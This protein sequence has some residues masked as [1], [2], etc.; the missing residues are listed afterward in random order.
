MTDK[1]PQDGGFIGNAGCTHENHEHSPLVERLIKATEPKEITEEE[2]LEALREG[3]YVSRDKKQ[4][5]FGKNMISHFSK[6][7]KNPKDTKRRLELL[8][9]A[10]DAV[11]T[12]TVEERHQGLEGRTAYMKSYEKFGIMAVS[13]KSGKNIE[14]VFNIIPDR[15]KRLREQ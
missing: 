9:F 6:P 2:A 3:F 13:D 12:G 11:K 5:G 14:Y 10:I 15:K 1:C 8:P 4:L 7:G